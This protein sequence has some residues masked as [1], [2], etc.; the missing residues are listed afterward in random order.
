MNRNL[1]I[2]TWIIMMQHNVSAQTKWGFENY[3]YWGHQTP[4]VFVPI[5]H[6]ET[7]ENWYAELRYNYEDIQT[8]S[9]YSGKIFAGGHSVQYSVTPMLGLSVGKFTGVSLA[10]NAEAAWK[11]FYVSSQ[12]QYS[13]AAKRNATNFFFS[14]SELGYNVSRNFFTGLASQYTLQTG[15]NDFEPGFLAGLNFK[16]VSFPFYVFSPFRAGRYFV[17]G[18]NYEYKLKKKE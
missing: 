16:N 8:L 4:G 9:L 1:L 15:R 2:I 18:L 13:M 11:D 17:L 6:F 7:K 12:T 10:T 3:N 5:V 14:W